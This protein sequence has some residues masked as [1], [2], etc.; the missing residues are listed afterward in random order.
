MRGAVG[1]RRENEGATQTRDE[2]GPAP[3]VAE[4]RGAEAQRSLGNRVVQHLLRAGAAEPGEAASTRA[5]AR[6]RASPAMSLAHGGAIQ[7]AFGRHD[8]SG[9][10]AHVG[11]DAEFAA[12]SIGAR[13]FAAGSHL[14]F[15]QAPSLRVAAHEAAHAVQQRH[16]RG[17]PQGEA[18]AACED[19]AEVVA[20]AVVAGRSAEPLLDAFAAAPAEGAG[21]GAALQRVTDERELDAPLKMPDKLSRRAAVYRE[22]NAV[23]V[24]TRLAATQHIKVVEAAKNVNLTDGKQASRVKIKW[25]EWH[26]GWQVKEGYVDGGDIAYGATEQTALDKDDERFKIVPPDLGSVRAA[27]VY[28]NGL[29]DCYLQAAMA[30]T[31]RHNPQAILDAIADNGR[32]VI[33]FLYLKNGALP[34]LGDQ[35]GELVRT[36]VLLDRSL[37]LDPQSR[38]VYGGKSGANNYLWPA[39]IGK[40]FAVLRGSYADVAMGQSYLAMKAL[41]GRG[42]GL[43]VAKS[44]DAGK[45]WGHYERMKAAI[46]ASKPVTLATSTFVKSGWASFKNAVSHLSKQ[47][48]LP[49]GQVRNLH[50]YAVMSI[51]PNNLTEQ[52]FQDAIPNVNVELRDPRDESGG[53]FTRTLK[54]IVTAG[55]F[56]S[57]HVG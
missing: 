38:P 47:G 20:D 49:Q 55:K 45:A 16:L 40:A 7:R 5:A 31:A 32:R 25:F 41:T 23:A 17:G 42:Q 57:L 4:A 6:G 30:A 44:S 10:V 3:A 56:T 53:T 11:G 8:V 46:A 29:S 22:A 24:M 35:E 26:A 48:D 18:R 52:D 28:Q 54:D 36:S 33:V 2:R 27:D 50:S 13:A 19:H 21:G 37:F 15:D 43:E 9:L 12:R 39:F 34:K 14:V 1:T 51:S